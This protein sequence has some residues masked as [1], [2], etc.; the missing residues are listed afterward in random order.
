[1]WKVLFIV[2][3]FMATGCGQQKLYK[4]GEREM[5][6]Y[7]NACFQCYQEEQI[8]HYAKAISCFE[9]LTSERYVKKVYVRVVLFYVAIQEYDLAR[10]YIIR[11]S[12]YLGNSHALIKEFYL[13]Y[14]SFF[15]TVSDSSDNA[16]ELSSIVNKWLG[17]YEE[18]GELFIVNNLLSLYLINCNPPLDT[19]LFVPN[20]NMDETAVKIRAEMQIKNPLYVLSPEFISFREQLESFASHGCR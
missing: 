15:E 1:M 9:Q 20:N 13:D 18:T 8:E 10:Q 5:Q 14:I 3:L 2:L 4:S 19:S 17:K 12:K 16:Q 11:N 7:Y 6:E